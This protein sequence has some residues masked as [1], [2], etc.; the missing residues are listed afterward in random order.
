M[1]S[2]CLIAE[3]PSERLG[4]SG[5]SSSVAPVTVITGSGSSP[6]VLTAS[7]STGA[8][9][10][11]SSPLVSVSLSISAAS[12]CTWPDGRQPRMQAENREKRR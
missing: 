4:A 1:K 2:N 11:S 6:E 8:P 10:D 12:P 3:K 7:S 9:V 5:K